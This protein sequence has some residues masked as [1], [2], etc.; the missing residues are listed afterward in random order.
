M[1]KFMSSLILISFIGAC[2]RAPVATNATDS[3]QL[4]GDGW[5]A[6]IGGGESEN[7]VLQLIRPDGSDLQRITFV[8]DTTTPGTIHAVRWPSWS[9]DGQFLVAEL[10]ELIPQLLSREWFLVTLKA[11]GSDFRKIPTM[12]GGRVPRWSPR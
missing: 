6:F 11:D 2:G 7:F 10:A 3:A 5:I 12:L 8:S 4:S 9:P 1:R